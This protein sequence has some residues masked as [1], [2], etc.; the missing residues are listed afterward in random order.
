MVDVFISYAR[1]DRPKCERI[2]AKL[3]ALELDVWFDAKLEAG[4]SFDREIEET[5]AKAKAVLVL[6]SPLS[7][8]SE[9]VRNEARVGKNKDKLVAARLADCDLPVEFSSIHFEDLSDPNFQDDHDGWLRLLERFARLTGRPSIVSFSRALAQAAQPLEQWA[10]ANPGDPLSDSMLSKA[11]LLGGAPP[12]AP[13]AA[14][15]RMLIAPVAAAALLA[16]G[17]GAAAG[18]ALRAPAATVVTERIVTPPATARSTAG[19]LAGRYRL[20]TETCAQP[21]ELWTRG[22]ALLM[23]SG[24]LDT[25]G[26]SASEHI[27]TEAIEALEPDGWLRTRTA[28]GVSNYYRRDGEAVQMRVG[29]APDAAVY[30]FEACTQ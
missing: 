8:K 15:P 6:W 18:F 25:A 22:S 19:E 3:R 26:Q 7:V 9:W 21:I 23:F 27:F 17:A 10:R 20:S 5:I 24:D 4:K 1:D 28:Q 12:A 30:V 13:R 16:L 11:S 14:R 2:A 29:D